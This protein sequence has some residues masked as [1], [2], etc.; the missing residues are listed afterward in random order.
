M[1]SLLMSLPLLSSGLK[2]VGITDMKT[3]GAMAT[4]AFG[5]L[6]TGLTTGIAGFK[7]LLASIGSVAGPLALVVGGFIA[8]KLA[9]EA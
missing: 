5:A 6:K 4:K 8:I 9:F 2:T 3:L 7:A 1:P